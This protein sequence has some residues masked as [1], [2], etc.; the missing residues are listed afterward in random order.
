LQKID[1]EIQK[2]E[3]LMVMGPS[4]SGKSTLLNILGLLDKI[5][6]GEYFLN[7]QPLSQ[8]TLGEYAKI[9][10]Q[11]IGMIFQAFNLIS[12]LNVYSN[13]ELPLIYRNESNK[14]CKEKVNAVSE[15]VN[16]QHRKNHYPQLLSG[17]EKQRVAI[18]RA[19]I[20]N[21]VL[22]LADEPTGNLDSDM[23]TEIMNLL[24][25]L[26]KEGKTIVMVT[27]NK[28]L[29]RYADRVIQIKDGKIF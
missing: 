29:T 28:E 17:G 8:K 27:H 2:G 1:L 12:D 3:F 22:L 13:V 23:S 26:N 20:I 5:D 7:N 6:E 10:N 14:A 24:R 16:I 21:P 25:D 4:G 9:R 18:A 15:K 11:N 19:L